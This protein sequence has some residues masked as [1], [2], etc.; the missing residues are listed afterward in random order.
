MS[1]GVMLVAAVLAG[2]SAGVSNDGQSGS[3]GTGGTGGTGSVATP[4]MTLA[5]SSNSV[6]S[7]A[8]VTVSANVLDAN[9]APVANALVTF[10]TTSVGQ[11]GSTTALTD[12][13]GVASVQLSPASATTV[14]AGTVSAASSVNG[15]GVSATANFQTTAVSAG[16]GT[17]STDQGTATTSRLAAY[18]QANLTLTLT[19]VSAASPATVAVT[20]ACVSAGKATI[21]PATVSNT[22]GTATFVYKDTG[23][24]GATN[25]SDTVTATITGSSATAATLQIFLT[26]PTVNSITF[27]STVIVGG[28]GSANTIYLK[29]SGYAESAQVRFKVVDT[30]GN[31]LPGQKVDLS[32]STVA[33]GLTLDGQSILNGRDTPEVKT[34]DANGIVTGIVN[35]GTV[36]TP[37]R[38][39]AT[40]DNTT[41]TTVSSNLAVLTGLPSQ[42]HFSLAQGTIN[43]E[44]GDWDGTPNTYTVT[45]SDRSGNP[46][47]DGTSIVFW[48]EGGTIVGSANTALNNLGL[49]Q[50]T[51]NF[52][53]SEPR[54]ADGR[55]TIL[56]YAIGEEAFIDLNGNNVWDP[57]E[58]FQDLGDIVKD[59]LHDGIYDPANDEFVSL[60]QVAVTPSSSAC[61]NSAAASY[62]QLDDTNFDLAIKPGS[63]DGTWSGK[64]YVRRETETVLSSSTPRPLWFAPTDTQAF[65]DGLPATTCRKVAL[66]TAPVTLQPVASSYYAADAGD[67][68]YTGTTDQAGSTGN[69]SGTLFFTVADQNALRLNPMPAGTTISVASQTSNVAFTVLGGSPVISTSDATLTGI[70]YTFNDKTLSSA[71][72]TV[73]YTTPRNVST[74]F[75][76]SLKVG[77][78]PTAC[79]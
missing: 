56:A 21:S 16:F 64:T 13:T 2:C 34:S 68:W 19:G 62:P 7:V 57:G 78:R 45:A 71:S 63:C 9:K 52:Q 70:S 29:G 60:A 18:A 50:A 17:F 67:I 79:Q 10:S 69:Y 61:D 48:A 35:S 22:S 72:F 59:V 27:D 11:L 46:V 66:R 40:L 3:G 38:V 28:S 8:P 58:P 39:I 54:P 15:T 49:S 43:I 44:G 65:N 12:S 36:P 4:S 53:S 23:G 26:S 32:L 31:P 76:Y 14:G 20:S 73:T 33:G 55:V 74:T 1:L 42:A 30:A 77:A 51:V 75:T 41:I 25:G 24:C 6:T 5:L 37:V 47:P